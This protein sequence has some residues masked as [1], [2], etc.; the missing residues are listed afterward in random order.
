M[1]DHKIKALF[2]HGQFNSYYFELSVRFSS[3]GGATM[4]A[5]RTEIRMQGIVGLSA[6]MLPEKSQ[7]SL[8]H[9]YSLPVA[10]M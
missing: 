9:S 10:S 4:N 6:K 5:L 3:L 1:F 2:R 7:Y 8:I